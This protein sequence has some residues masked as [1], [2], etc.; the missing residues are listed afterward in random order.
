MFLKI[1]NSHEDTENSMAEK[2]H[3]EMKWQSRLV[4]DGESWKYDYDLFPELPVVDFSTM[5]ESDDYIENCAVSADGLWA[6]CRRLQK[7]GEWLDCASGSRIGRAT[8]TTDIISPAIWEKRNGNWATWMS[9][10]PQEFFTLR[11]GT[12]KARGHTI[13]GGLGMGYQLLEVLQRDKVQKVAV[14]EKS[15]SLIDFLQAP[16]RKQFPE[17]KQVNF[18]CGDI[19][20]VLPA[21]SADVALIDIFPSYGNNQDKLTKM[22]ASAPNIKT[23]WGW[24]TSEL[25]DNRPILPNW[26]LKY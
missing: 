24:G 26:L 13:I 19:Y 1:L 12:R 17:G 9:F 23:W 11:P 16:L 20:N 18:I 15:Q 22:Q 7:A 6:Y 14:I 10:T 5:K 8:F 2:F 3:K 25:Y 21:L 4:I